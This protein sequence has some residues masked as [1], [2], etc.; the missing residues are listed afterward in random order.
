[1]VRVRHAS[2]Y[3]S[4]YL[5]L[6]RFAEG[7]RAGV[8]VSQ[9]QRIGYVGSTGLSTGPHLH[10]GLTKNGVFVNPVV[11][12]RNMPPGEPIPAPAMAAF[13]EVRDRELAALAA[14]AGDEAD[15]P[16]AAQAAAE[17]GFTLA[18]SENQTD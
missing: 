12:H 16:V 3:Q 17:H 1:M 8:R 14:A 15:A 13:L 18:R 9:G 4:Y 6:S 11:E 10:Y 5:H 7:I 2:G